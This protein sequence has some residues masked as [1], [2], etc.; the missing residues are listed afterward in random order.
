VDEEKPSP[1][2]DLVTGAVWLAV[3]IGIMV[4][5]WRMDRLEHLATNI[6]TAPGL[7]PGLLGAAIALMA[8][9]L[10]ARAL[11]ASALADV[12]LPQITLADHWRLIAALGLS[13]VFAVALVGHGLPFWLAAAIYTA[14]M[15][16][17]FQYADR[18]Q[19]GTLVR[20]AAFAAVFGIVTGLIVH[21]TFQD[22]FLVRLP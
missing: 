12:R 2:A 6:Y 1:F 5:A 10:M 9:I 13:L 3:A 19:A 4:G 15:I 16:F 21:F 7:V 18:R 8:A 11:Y 17:V 20:G 14:L 22:V